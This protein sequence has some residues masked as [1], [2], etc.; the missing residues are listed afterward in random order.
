MKQSYIYVLDLNLIPILEAFL[1]G[2]M[3][4]ALKNF[5]DLGKGVIGLQ[6]E[7]GFDVVD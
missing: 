7:D 1:E 2:L 5:L 4:A 6:V 3:L